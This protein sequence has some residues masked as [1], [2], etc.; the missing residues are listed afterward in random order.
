MRPSEQGIPSLGSVCVFKISEFGISKFTVSK[1]GRVRSCC[2]VV[3][4]SSGCHVRQIV[5]SVI[6]KF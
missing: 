5:N 6:V 2:V 3:R 4:L 1:E